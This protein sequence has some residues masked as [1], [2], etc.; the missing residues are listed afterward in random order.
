MAD[1]DQALKLDPNF[2][3]AYVNRGI[4][5]HSR[6][7]HDRAIAD[8]DAAIRLAPDNA[9]AYNN[10]GTALDAKGEF[11]RALADFDRAIELD[12]K[13]AGFYDNRGNVWRNKGEFDRGDCGLRPGHRAAAGL[14]RSRSTTARRCTISPAALP[15]RWPTPT[16]SARLNSGF[17]AGTQ[18]ARTDPA[19]S[20]APGA[21]PSPISAARPRSIRACRSL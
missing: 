11:D 5:W 13:S 2:A 10:R 1:Y 12:P 6:K 9:A 18:P 4:V 14:T 19:K 3:L 21:P 20:S 15:M 8:F 16:T 7:D 17:R